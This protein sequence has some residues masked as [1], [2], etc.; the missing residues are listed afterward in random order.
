MMSLQAGVG[1]KRL[2]TYNTLI[3]LTCPNPGV[4]PGPLQS[5]HQF[6]DMCA[7]QRCHEDLELVFVL[8]KRR[9]K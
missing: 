8:K 4:F 3:R 2:F 5:K 6:R 9:K 1:F 7:L